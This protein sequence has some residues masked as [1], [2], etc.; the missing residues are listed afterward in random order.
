ML[1][2]VLVVVLVLVLVVVLRPRFGIEA[3][4]PDGRG[5]KGESKRREFRSYHP[6]KMPM[7]AQVVIDA[8]G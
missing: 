7:V 4:L 5:L 3:A 6:K 8:N 2:M 1:P